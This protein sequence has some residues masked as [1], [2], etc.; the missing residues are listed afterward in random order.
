M[1][2]DNDDPD[3][4]KLIGGLLDGGDGKAPKARKNKITYECP[5]C[6]ARVWGK[7]NLSIVCGECDSKFEPV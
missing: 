1:A 4:S 6:Q 7:P 2:G 5:D 3:L